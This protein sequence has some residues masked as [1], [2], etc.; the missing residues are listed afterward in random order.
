[1]CSLDAFVDTPWREQAQWWGDAR[2]QAWNVFHL[3]GDTQL[4]RRGI[5]QIA[6]QT[7]PNGLTY[8]HAPT[9]AHECILPD[10]TLIWLITLVPQPCLVRRR[11][12]GWVV[13]TPRPAADR[14]TGGGND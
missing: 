14:N 7:L 11:G 6:A 12:G 2:V 9:M 8:G 5:A 1:M 3:N 4:F 13:L 10:F